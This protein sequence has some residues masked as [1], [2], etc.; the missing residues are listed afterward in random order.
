MGW[1]IDTLLRPE[2]TT[3]PVVIS[4]LTSIFHDPETAH[5]L[6]VPLYERS[7]LNPR[8]WPVTRDVAVN[9][10]RALASH[11]DQSRAAQLLLKTADWLNP[12][13]EASRYSTIS[14]KAFLGDAGAEAILE[15]IASMATRANPTRSCQLTWGT[16]AR[17]TDRK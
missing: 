13:H 9:A 5:K 2:G 14:F 12:N 3:E 4:A 8:R 6:P 1:I 7:L 11:P 17:L 16:I 10:I 15:S